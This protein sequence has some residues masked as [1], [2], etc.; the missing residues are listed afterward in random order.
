MEMVTGI[1][2]GAQKLTVYS[3]ADTE[4]FELSDNDKLLGSYAIEDHYRIHV[5]NTCK[6]GV[7]MGGGIGGIVDFN[8]TSKVE[9]YVMD[10][11]E[12]DNMRGTVRD[13]KRKMK[14][15]RFNAEEVAKQA[16][17]KAEKDA[18]YAEL[19]AEKVK[20]VKVGDRCLVQM[21]K[22]PTRRG[23]VKFVG[24]VEFSAGIWA[25][26]ELDEPYG[27]NDGS[28]KGKRYFT[29]SDKYGS[30]VKVESVECGDF[31]PEDDELDGLD[32]I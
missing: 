24:N 5:S 32:E 10:E 14:M 2:A 15:G 20:S 28:V 23:C 21:A 3:T 31:P 13:F 18:A 30:F 8:D 16:E 19:Q 27:K 26:V 22:Q 9:K 12:Y 4:L 7:S 11:N 17:E 1:P 25:G 6:T 29:C